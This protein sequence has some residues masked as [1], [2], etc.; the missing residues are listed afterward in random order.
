MYLVP[1][2]ASHRWPCRS[3]SGAKAKQKR[4]GLRQIGLGVMVTRD[5]RI[6]LAW[7]AYSGDRPDVTQFP[8][9]ID[10]LHGQYQAVCAAAEVPAA[11]DMTVVFDAGHNSEDNFA[12][13]AGTGRHYIRS[14][15]TS[16]YSRSGHGVPPCCASTRVTTVRSRSPS[17]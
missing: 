11:A 5:G 12:H 4:S 2:G 8:A 7:H 6:P 16:S 17:P 14:A 9:M 10:Q 13:L 15:R 1:R 3:R